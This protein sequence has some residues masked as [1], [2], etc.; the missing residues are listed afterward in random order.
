[1]NRLEPLFFSP[2]SAL[3]GKSKESFSRVGLLAIGFLTFWPI[4]P[5]YINR[6]LDHSDDPWGILALIACVYFLPW[7]RIDKDCS[8]ITL[9]LVS[10]IIGM[11][12]LLLPHLPKVIQALFAITLLAVILWET[13][14][15]SGWYAL[16]VLSLPLIATLQF[17]VGYPLRLLIGICS[18]HLLSWC[19]LPVTHEEAALFWKDSIV[20]IDA[21]CSGIS[22]MWFGAFLTACLACKARF[23]W[24]L[25]ALAAMGTTLC[26]FG[27]NL[28]RN[29]ILFFP[30]SGLLTWPTWGHMTIGLILFAVA[31]LCIFFWIKL[32]QKRFSI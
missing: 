17:Y 23:P 32:L 13:R 31:C 15:P 12:S 14:P 11:Y 21:P 1:M 16:L 5:W 20:L 6:M 27:L 9:G 10:I 4:W 19:G 24:K 8:K 30:E 22:M 26:I 7:S 29:L 2:G 3:G 25:T 18:S 28:L